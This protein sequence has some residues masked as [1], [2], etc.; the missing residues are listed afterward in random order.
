MASM[1]STSSSSSPP[2][3]IDLELPEF[4]IDDAA[5][6]V[7]VPEYADRLRAASGRMAAAGLDVL[8][9][10]AD[11]EHSANI[12]FLTGFDPRFEEALLIIDAAG[13]RWLLVGNECMSYLPD[14]SLGIEAVLF[15]EFS[16]LGQPRGRSRP[17]RQILADCGVA[18]GRRI[19]CVGW[20]YFEGPLVEGGALALDL[21]SYLA[22]TIRSLAGDPA[23]VVNATALMM[24]PRDGMRLANSAAQIAVFEHASCLTSSSVLAAVRAI[25]VGASEREI[26][27]SFRTDGMPLSCHP[28]VSFGDKAARGLASPGEGR[29]RIGDAYTLALGVWGALNC[30]A[31][32]VV[33]DSDGLPEALRSFYPRL[34]ANF[35][36]VMTAWYQALRVG[37][38]G[39]EVFRAAD[40]ARDPSLFDFALNPG[41]YLHLDEWVHSPFAEGD[42]SVLPSGAAIQMDIIPVSRGPACGTNGED[43]VVLADGALCAELARSYPSCW[44][45]IGGRRRFMIGTLGIHLHESVLPLSNMPAWLPPYALAPQRAFANR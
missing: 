38:T 14:S 27:R 3:L 28:M 33:A 16:L 42:G 30:R 44:R 36:Q 32:M 20:K 11:R 45:R 37:A 7:P 23:R 13:R 17:L 15:Q 34:V 25:R 21:P 4:G 2:Q 1:L 29:A 10:Y 22:D 24:N 40:R 18:S 31:G 6:V 35:F 12:A 26:A 39:G 9:V 5:P 41:H 19:G 8:V 43:G